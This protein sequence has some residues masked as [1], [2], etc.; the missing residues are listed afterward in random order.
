MGNM[1]MEYLKNPNAPMKIIDAVEAIID[2]L[3]K[4]PNMVGCSGFFVIKIVARPI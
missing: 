1:I 3:K 4:I 2:D